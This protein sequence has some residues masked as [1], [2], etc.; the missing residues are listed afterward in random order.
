MTDRPKQPIDE[1]VWRDP[2]E[3]HTNNYNPNKVFGPELETLALSIIEDGWTGCVLVTPDLEVVDGFHRWTLSLKHAGV[4]RASGGMVPTVMIRNTATK[5]DRMIATVRH[6]RARGQHGILKMSS[7]VR[8][9]IA[10]G[11]TDEEIERRLGMEDEELVRLVDM[12]GSPDQAGKDSFG[13]GWTPV[14]RT[15]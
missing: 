5:A 9:L 4:R 13:K 3:L 1:V 7:I 14:A 11:L 15:K 10:Q 2:R 12:R 6:N 8:E